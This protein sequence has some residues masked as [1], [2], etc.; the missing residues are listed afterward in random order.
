MR[1]LHRLRPALALLPCIARP[2]LA[3]WP[4]QP[5]TNVP[6]CTATGGQVSP[7]MVSDGAGGAIITWSD[8]RSG[9]SGDIYAQRVE[10]FG[11]LG[12]PEPVIVSLKDVPNDQGGQ[13]KVSWA[14]SYLDALPYNEI[15]TYAI[16]RSIPPQ[17]A[18]SRLHAGARLVSARQADG[19]VPGRS[20]R[21]VRQGAQTTYWEFVGNQQAH[22]FADYSYDL[23]TSS[24]PVA[25]SNPL[26]QVLV[27]AKHTDGSSFWNSAPDS[28]Y[29]VDNLPP[30]EPAP[31]LGYSTG[32]STAMHWRENVERDLSHYNLYRGTSAGFVPGPANRIASTSDTAYTDPTPGSF[33]FKLSAVDVHGNESPFALLTPQQTGS[34]PGGGAAAL[35]LG[36]AAPNPMHRETTIRYRL[37]AEAEVSLAIFDVSGA[38]VR[39]LLSGRAPAGPGNVTWDG[40]DDMGRPADG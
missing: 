17:A 34:V 7:A 35:W 13:V 16:W 12:N 21:A 4:N 30:A 26:L 2:A 3:A 9:D 29:S 18:A 39:T 1:S 36:P 33:Y 14:A 22:R 5:A 31:F 28:G 27:V 8:N 24:D 38:R 19:L 32:S 23:S 15:S 11:R 40:R 20:L 10:A 37:P 25:G 6:V